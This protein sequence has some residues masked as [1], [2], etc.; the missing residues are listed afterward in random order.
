MKKYTLKQLET[1]PTLHSG[2]FDNLKIE[3][4]DTRVWLSRMTIEDGMEYNNQVTV[5]AYQH[6]KTTK[7][8]DQSRGKIWVKIQEYEAK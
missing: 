2:H 1:L 3:T 8:I 7:G 4:K 6:P 5:E